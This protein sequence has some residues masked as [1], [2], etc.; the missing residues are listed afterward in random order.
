VPIAASVSGGC[1]CTNLISQNTEAAVRF[2]G[3]K[4]QE[5]EVYKRLVRDN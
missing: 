4:Y 1:Y 5:C 2:C 3:G